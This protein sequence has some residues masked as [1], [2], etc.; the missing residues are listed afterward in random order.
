ML[1]KHVNK[2]F[3]I[4]EKAFC[5]TLMLM[6]VGFSGWWGACRH[7]G[8]STE[9][10]Q[11]HNG[12]CHCPHCRC[13]VFAA[14][15]PG[16]G[17]DSTH[18]FSGCRTPLRCPTGMPNSSV[19][20]SLYFLVVFFLPKQAFSFIHCFSRPCAK[21]QFLSFSAPPSRAAA[22]AE[23]EALPGCTPA[24]ATHTP[25]KWLTDHTTTDPPECNIFTIRM[26]AMVFYIL[27]IFN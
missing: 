13:Q 25:S 7:D 24:H 5:C 8:P 18:Q 2:S 1:L 11:D 19:T 12:S 16:D 6:H 15:P 3:I 4:E 27:E 14:Q 26:Y 20:L 17:R 21:P 9:T 22:P 23:A 10:H